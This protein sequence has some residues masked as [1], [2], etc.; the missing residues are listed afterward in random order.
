[1]A[2]ENLGLDSGKPP[3]LYIYKAITGSGTIRVLDLHKTQSGYLECSITQINFEEGAYQA[4]SYEWGS[5]EQPFGILVQGAKDEGLGRIPLT[6]NLFDAL[7]DLHNCP[8]IQPKRFWIDQI[9]IN[10]ADDEE[11][12]HKSS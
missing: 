12:G 5:L 6:K 8:D 11:K 9:C 3:N 2:T 10:Q 1:M 4:L 7:G